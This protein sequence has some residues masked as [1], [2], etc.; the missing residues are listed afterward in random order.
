MENYKLAKRL[1]NDDKS[2]LGSLNKFSMLTNLKNKIL[3]SS[4]NDL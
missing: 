2:D 4:L 3:A 1:I